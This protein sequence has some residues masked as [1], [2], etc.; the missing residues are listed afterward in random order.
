MADIESARTAFERFDRDGDGLITAN[1]YKSAMA[2]L[3][4]PFV[5]ETVAQAIINAHDG[6]G[7]GMLT[8]D[9]FWASQNKV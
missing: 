2:Q 1:E 3:G 8:F 6:N 5:T 9:E 7:D 4:D